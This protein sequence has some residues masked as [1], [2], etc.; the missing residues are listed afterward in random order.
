ML[1]SVYRAPVSKPLGRPFADDD[2]LV[3]PVE[4]VE[5]FFG[6]SLVEMTDGRKRRIVDAREEIAEQFRDIQA[7]ISALIERLLTDH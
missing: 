1:C 2:F 3:S 7:E 6:I 5:R 4:M